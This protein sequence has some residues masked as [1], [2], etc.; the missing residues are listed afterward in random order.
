MNST[1]TLGRN[2]SLGIQDFAKIREDN[3][4]YVDKTGY[5]YP[6]AL[7]GKPYFLGRP[8]RFGKSL[9]LSTLKYYFQGRKDLFDDTNGRTPL[10]IASMEK[11]WIKHPVFHLDMNVSAYSSLADL[12]TGLDANLRF[13]EE[14]WGRD[15]GDTTAPTRFLGLI[16]RAC[17][18]SGQK[19]VVLVDEYDR[20]LTQNLEEKNGTLLEDLRKALK[21]FY[22]ILKTADPYLRFLFLTGVTK[23]SKVSVFSDLNQLI[24][25]SLNRDFSEICGVTETE[26]SAVFDPEIRALGEQHGLEYEAARERLRQRYNGYHFA[27]ASESVYNP[28]SLL[29]AF[30]SRDF[31]SYWF[32]SGTPTFLVEAFRRGNFYLPSLV[33]GGEPRPGG[34]AA[35]AGVSLGVDDL[36]DYRYTGGALIPLLYQSGYLTIKDYDPLLREC[37]LGFPNDEVKYGFL[38]NLLVDYLPQEFPDPLSLGITNF[39]KDLRREDLPAF[40]GRLDSLFANL[41]YGTEKP[42]EYYFH[43]FAYLVFILLGQYT[44]AEVHHQGGRTDA[45]IIFESRVY[46][47]E[48]KVAPPAELEAAAGEA[49]AQIEERGYDRPYRGGGERRVVKIGAAFNEEPAKAGDVLRWRIG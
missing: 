23:F 28:F 25:L 49:L 9:F 33:A 8:R 19:V 13:I 36:F 14:T 48:F 34:P 40:M 29:N 18:K 17:E 4:L 35:G 41:P 30:F 6:L 31:G 47:F 26:L 2:L 37:T 44:Q 15:P 21:G 16:R 7:Q 5:I 39:V 22:G 42:R 20:P 38:D 3:C 10:A 1:F 27:P 32:G 45:V 46:V 24:D 43:S 12:E 11:D